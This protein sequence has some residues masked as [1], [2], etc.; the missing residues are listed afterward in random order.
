MGSTSGSRFVARTASAPVADTARPIKAIRTKRV[1][2]PQAN[3]RSM[4]SLGIA[5]FII[6]TKFRFVDGTDYGFDTHSLR[7]L[8]WRTLHAFWRG[9]GREALHLGHSA[10]VPKRHSHL[11]DGRRLWQWTSRRNAGTSLE[12]NSAR[13]LLPRRRGWPRLLHRQAGRFQRISSFYRPDTAQSQ[14]VCRLPYDGR[15]AGTRT[16][17]CQQI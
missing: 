17:G 10:C 5:V 6:W 9:P 13:Q 8:E 3:R 16:N 2:K 11:H 7:Y 4:L 15:L 1:G 14:S 12:R